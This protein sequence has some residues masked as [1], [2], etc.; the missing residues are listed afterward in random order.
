MADRATAP[1]TMVSSH[2]MKIALGNLPDWVSAGSTVFALAFA[3]IAVIVARRSFLIESARDEV[4][5]ADRR[6]QAAFARRAQAALV[7]AW[8]G[9]AELGG[10]AGAFVRNASNAPV[11]QAHLTVLDADERSG[12]TKI[13]AQVLPP[14]DQ[15]RFFPVEAMAAG[16]PH[17]VQFCFTDAAGVRWMRNPYGRLTELGSTLRIKTDQLRADAFSQ[18][19]EDFLATHGVTITYEVDSARISQ[20]AFTDDLAGPGVADALIAPHDWIGDLAERGIIEPTVLSDDHRQAFPAWALDAL[21]V[22]DRLYG[23]PMTIDTVALIRNVELAPDA[24]ATFDELIAMGEDL[25]ADGRVPEVFAVRVGDQGDPFQI[26]PIFASAGGR[27]FGRTRDG[28]WDATRLELATPESVAAF[29]LLRSLGES[30]TGMIRRS[31]RR[32]EAFDAFASRRTAFLITDSDGMLHARNAGVPF[33]VSAVPPF[34]GGEPAASFTLV[35][36]LLMTGRGLN[37]AIAHDLFADYLTQP[38]VTE[39]LSR[40]IV[41]PVAVQSGQTAHDPGIE[42]YQRLC[43]T[44]LPMPT[45]PQMERTWRILGRAQAAAISGAPAAPTAES[46]AEEISRL[47]SP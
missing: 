34:D 44:G 35:H 7:C 14:G 1:L 31:V 21:T 16:G 8:W 9:P 38:R 22:G 29:E 12:S 36:G 11:Y 25:R 13:H 18:F 24:P 47:F 5:E 28:D 20:V 2:A 23:I 6:E 4:N 17:R 15:A 37:K 27:I 19:G 26:W 33:S 3:A 43:E 42:Q 40:G 41:C 32:E 10:A 30:G 46:A 39:A 45:F